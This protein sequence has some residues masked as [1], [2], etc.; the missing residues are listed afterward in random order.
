MKPLTL[1]VLGC[2]RI[3]SLLEEDPLRGKPCTHAGGFN[4][5]KSVKII[6]GCDIDPDRLARFG[7]RWGVN[8]LYTRYEELLACE[9]PDLVSVAAWTRVHHEMVMASARAGVKG[10]FCE[11]PIALTVK[12][13]QAMVRSCKRRGIPLVIN[14]ER[15]WEPYYELAYQMIRKGTIGELRTIIGNA[16]SGNPGK[17]KVSEQ[18]GGPMFHDGTH[19]TDLLLFFGGPVA[20]VSGNE[21]RSHGKKHIEHTASAMLQFKSGATGYIE[22]GGD[23]RYFNF[24]LDLQG[25]EGRILIGNAGRELYITK[26]SGR[27]SGFQELERVPFPEPKKYESPFIGGARDLVGAIRKKSRSAS[28]GEDGLSAL[29]LI[30]AVYDSAKQKGKRVRP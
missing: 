4:A 6:A 15:R 3:G 21:K 30:H 16:L 8:K 14:H 19:L 1:A 11:K 26:N 20:W 10:I 13:G 2:G 23:R 17:H 5:L 9:T 29:K 7:S 25:S 28:S 22:G 18:G 24:E 27:F 12:E